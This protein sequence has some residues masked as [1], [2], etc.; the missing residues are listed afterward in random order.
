MS[1]FSLI[2]GKLSVNTEGT[3]TSIVDAQPTTALMLATTDILS[4][5]DSDKHLPVGLP[6]IYVTPTQ[7]GD[8][9][10]I[11]RSFNPLGRITGFRSIYPEID[12]SRS[13]IIQVDSLQIETILHAVFSSRREKLP[14]RADGYTEWFS[15]DLVDAVVDFCHHL[16]FNRKANYTV[17]RDL[18]SLMQAYR[19]K[20]PLAGLRVPRLT[21]EQRH[22]RYPLIL[23]SLCQ[24]TTDQAHHFTE[25]LAEREFDG[26]VCREGQ[27]FLV[28]T[29]SRQ[30]EPECWEPGNRGWGSAWS[31]RLLEM[32]QVSAHVDGSMCNFHFLKPAT[33]DLLNDQQGREWHR[34][35][36]G[37]EGESEPHGDATL[38]I[39]RA[40]E[41]FWN[42]LA[43]LEVS[44][45]PSDT[46]GDSCNLS[47]VAN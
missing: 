21:T 3:C 22:A 38:P 44:A 2:S 20:N 41:V 12:L 6:Y 36:Q 31:R 11:G 46:K 24:A 9:S 33:F 35:A 10:K 26:I 25:V 23:E 19:E 18:R 27:Y 17:I 47:A 45:Y 7:D 37:P 42:A 13:V 34:I 28:R 14:H 30:D 16:A 32:A 8:K 15:G 4:S 43:H 5:L 29:V 39:D 1:Q 40:F